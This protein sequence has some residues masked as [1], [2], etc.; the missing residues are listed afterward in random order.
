MSSLED[1]VNGI[2]KEIRAGLRNV[3]L[4]FSIEV[5]C[6]SIQVKCE[7]TIFVSQNKMVAHVL[8][9]LLRPGDSFLQDEDWTV[10]CGQEMVDELLRRLVTAAF[11][12]DRT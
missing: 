10:S 2:K 12:K 3:D 11:R 7:G 5:W 8:S 4:V 9:P 6:D 1:L